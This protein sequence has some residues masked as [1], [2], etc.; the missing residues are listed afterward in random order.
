[1]KYFGPKKLANPTFSQNQKFHIA[2]D[3]LYYQRV[4]MQK[5]T[6]TEK[7]IYY[8]FIRFG[9]FSTISNTLKL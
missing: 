6:E 7:S 3:P 8:D 4:H 2:K 5:E 9:D 1:M